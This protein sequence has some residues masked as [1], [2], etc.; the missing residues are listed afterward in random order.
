[1]KTALFSAI[2]AAVLA[3][4]IEGRPSF[5]EPQL[6]E[7]PAD[8]EIPPLERY[9]LLLLPTGNLEYTAGQPVEIRFRLLN[10]D[11]VNVLLYEWHMRETENIRIYYQPYDP[12]Q[13][14]P[15]AEWQCYEPEVKH[16]LHYYQ[17]ELFPG[18]SVDVTIPL[19]F[20]EKMPPGAYL[21]YAELTLTSVDVASDDFV[22]TLH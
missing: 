7:P 1:M 3:G 16:P 13:P 19:P 8:L 5:Y 21:M 12:E 14:E 20:L 18:N 17:L 9:H 11:T 6:I 15:T 2:L 22:V 4:C 10:K